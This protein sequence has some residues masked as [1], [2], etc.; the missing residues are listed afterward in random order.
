MSNEP[1]HILLVDDDDVTNFL[2]R[3]MLRLYMAS[4]KVDITLNGQ[5][6]VD[7]LLERSSEP[8]RLPNLIL[9]DINMPIMDG[10]DFLTE[11]D[12]IKRSGFE[13]INIVMF[14]SSVYYEDIDRARTYAS[15]KNIYS[16]PLDEQKIK[17]IIASCS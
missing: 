9:L 3:E 2:S 10:W 1:Y 7:Y 12:K 15:V 13:K 6:T 11:F 4:P 5:E 17:E 14:T 16:K 8:Q